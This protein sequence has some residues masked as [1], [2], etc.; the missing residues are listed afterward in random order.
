[1][2]QS[3]ELANRSFSLSTYTASCDL[4]LVRY[5]LDWI[6]DL[7]AIDLW[8][9]RQLQNVQLMAC[10]VAKG[11][12][13]LNS[14]A[15]SF[16]IRSITVSQHLSHPTY[17]QINRKISQLQLSDPYAPSHA[18]WSLVARFRTLAL[19]LEN[20]VSKRP[21]VQSSHSKKRRMFVERETIYENKVAFSLKVSKP[22]L[23]WFSWDSNAV[24]VWE[25]KLLSN[26]MRK[27]F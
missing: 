24:V 11:S 12:V 2:A 1:M 23:K 8:T 5:L 27:S 21:F 7:A 20:D 19:F 17:Q 9:T 26:L 4:R 25:W 18:S 6:A 16:W 3:T 10:S 13:R 14:E 22:C 15:S